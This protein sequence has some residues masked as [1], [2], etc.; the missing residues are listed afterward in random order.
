[1]LFFL[2]LFI[3]E[4]LVL[5]RTLS[6]PPPVERCPGT[7]CQQLSTDGLRSE[8]GD[9]RTTASSPPRS[10]RSPTS[11]QTDLRANTPSPPSRSN[12]TSGGSD[13]PMWT[14]EAGLDNPAFEESTEED[15]ESVRPTQLGPVRSR[16]ESSHRP[17]AGRW[18]RPGMC[19]PEGEE[20]PQ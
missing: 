16:V 15:G 13:G 11:P 9:E 10:P 18:S 2:L 19:G 6:I 3:S 12:N 20:A 17:P 5:I 14:E 7:R 8:S 4:S 1:M